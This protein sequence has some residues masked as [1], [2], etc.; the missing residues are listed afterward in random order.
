MKRVMSFILLF[1]FFS[2]VFKFLP[3]QEK[4]KELFIKPE[5]LQ[6]LSWRSIGPAH[7]GGRVADVAGIPGDPRHLFVAHSSAGLFVSH[8]GGTTF[9]S[10]FNQGNT[11][12]I[13]AIAISP[14]HPEIIYVGTGEGDPRNSASFGDGIYK[15]ED[16]GQTWVHLG[17]E[18]AERFSKIILHPQNENIIF[19]AAMGHAWGPNETR[20]LFRSLDGGKTWEKILYVNSTTGCSDVC[21]DPENPNI[22]YAGMY[23]YLRQPWHF[24][25]G[26][27]GSGLYRSS[28]GGETWTKLTNPELH[29]GLP[30]GKLLGR[31]GIAGSQSNPEV[32]YAIIES[33]EPGVL[34]RSD[35]RGKTWKMVCAEQRINNRPFYYSDIRVD[36]TDENTV[37][38]LAGELW[39]SHDGGRNFSRL[40]DYWG[41]FGDNHALWI[42][43]KN[44]FRLLLGND[45]GFFI[46]NDRG[47]TWRFVNNMP[48]A[49]AYHVGVDMAEPYH[50]MGGFQDHEI[51]WGPN[52]KWNEIGVTQG[53]WVRLRD[54]AD[55]MYALADPR[56]PNIIYYNGHFGDITRV[57]LKTGEER[58]I[59]PYP[60][61]PTGC[62]AALELF[63]FNWNSPIH[64]SPTNPDVIYYGGNVIFKT[65]DGGE[66]WSIISPDLTTAD[67]EKMKLSGGPITLDNTRAEFHCTILT[68]AESPV[69]SQVIWAGTDDGNLQL[70]RDGGKTW[71][72]VSKNIPGLP[73]NAWMASIK[74]SWKEA[75][76]A[77]LA[78]DQ[79]R[80]DDFQPY[81]FVTTDYGQTWKNISS[82]LRGYVHVVAEDPRSPNLLFAGTELGIFVSFDRGQSWSDLR[83]GLPPL[84]V[85][86]L[87]VHPR[88]NDLVI[89]TH[90]RGFYILDDITLLQELA[91]V[92]EK[93]FFL[94]LPLPAI[95]YT[96]VSDTSTVG[97]HVFVGKNQPYG[98]L[99]SYWVGKPECSEKKVTVEVINS[100]GEV[101]A[102]FLGP[103]QAGINRVVWNLREDI[104]RGE[105]VAGDEKWY[106]PLRHGPRVLPGKYWVRLTYKGYS[107]KQSLVVRLDPRI[108]AKG[109]DLE[110]YYD[111]VTRLVKMEYKINQALFEIDEITHSLETRLTKCKKEEKQRLITILGQLSALRF[112]LQPHRNDPDHLNLRGKTGWLLKQVRNYTGRPTRAQLE[113]MAEFE[114]YLDDIL[115]EFNQLKSE[116]AEMSD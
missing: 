63:R 84:A 74:T 93:D 115:R 70:T 30:G 1:T 102:R 89:A 41:R 52:E 9:T 2:V 10:I 79:H 56:D 29:N 59:Q 86:D 39:V 114:G 91:N 110:I 32:V 81:A 24:R 107:Q 97:D 45:G 72:N 99:I 13:G 66:T 82:G 92:Y 111:A 101:I 87:V 6:G 55:G 76:T 58:F 60:V 14:S 103:A 22:I 75:G 11:L 5:L 69:D 108:K 25:S 98:A 105:R 95:R 106:Q 38:A 43:P 80:L 78:V 104:M 28:D 46:S 27:P 44:P 47:Q 36:P 4:I 51:W 61:G 54:M 49:Q 57:D 12:S 40:G 90:A 42:D 77:Y 53:D 17:L 21:F 96:P 34:W 7:F 88:D 100:K 31:I 112:D 67:P 83:L 8:N 50:V 19:A 109:D 37:Y 71:T 33:Q 65:T 64:M 113:W 73:S 35:D 18:D 94:F 20:G 26:G 15:T 116:W 48:F 3:A 68:I 16:G 85:R 23:D 62:S